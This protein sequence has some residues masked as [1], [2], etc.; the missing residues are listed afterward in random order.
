MKIWYFHHYATPYEIAGLHRPFEF[1]SYLNQS[2]NQIAVFTSSYLHYAGENMIKGKEKILLREYDGVTSVF[3]RTCGYQNKI[4]RVMNMVQFGYRLFEAS[5]WFAKNHWKPDIIVASIPHPLAALSALKIAKKY[6]IPCICEVRD[7]WPEVFFLGGVV[8]ERG[9]IGKFLLHYERLIYEKADSL[10]FLKEGDH[11][12]ISDHKWDTANGGKVDISKCAYINNGVDIQ[13]FDRRIKECTY[14][15]EDLETDKF[16]II[17]CGTI[18]P[19]NNIGMLLDVAKKLDDDAIV[20]IYG[21]GNCVEELK[22]R[23]VDEQINNVRFKGYVNNKYIPYIL[24]KSS[25]NILNYSGSTYN[26]SRGNSSNKLFEYLASG[27]P[28]VST[29]KMGYD[30]IERDNCG[31]SVEECTV[32]NIVEVI[33]RVRKLSPAEYETIC[34]SARNT[35]EKFDIPILAKRYEQVLKDTI[36]QFKGE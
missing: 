29:V 18:R 16:K 8:K 1:G 34:K 28:V 24:S 19:V 32:D 2:G 27:K 14:P 36:K 23:V 33:N 6:N 31:Y 25:L 17:Y 9:L 21:M 22:Q 15:D 30:I 4:N 10:V 11:T 20:L 5:K 26:W 7:L 3:V 35:A 12:Y 13:L